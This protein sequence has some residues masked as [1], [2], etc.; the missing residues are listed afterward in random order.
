MR[1]PLVPVLAAL[2]LLSVACDPDDAGG[3]LWEGNPTDLAGAWRA[4]DAE[5]QGRSYLLIELSGVYR[6]L[7]ES[8]GEAIEVDRGSY[9]LE[10]GFLVRVTTRNINPHRVGARVENG[11]YRVTASELV[12]EPEEPGGAQ[13]YY[14]RVA[15]PPEYRAL[16]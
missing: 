14:N 7:V 4:R 16:P 3:D 1:R 10:G 15:A 12:L 6:E 8:A 13:R 5:P 2:C 11:I 9:I